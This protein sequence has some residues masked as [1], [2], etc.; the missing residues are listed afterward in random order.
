LWPFISRIAGTVTFFFALADI[1]K[2]PVMDPGGAKRD[3]N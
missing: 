2:P 3:E 1:K